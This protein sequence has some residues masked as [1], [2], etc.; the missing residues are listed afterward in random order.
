M[1]ITYHSGRRIQ[2]TENA[3]QS[4]SSSG[5]G[6]NATN[7]NSGFSAVTGLIGQGYSQSSGIYRIGTAP[8]LGTEWSFNFWTNPQAASGNDYYLQMTADTSPRNSVFYM[9]NHNTDGL[10][11]GVHD[12]TGTKVSISTDDSEMYVDMTEGS[13]NMITMTWNNTDKKLRSYK[14]GVLYET[15]K[16]FTYTNAGNMG[17]S[18]KV[19]AIGNYDNQTGSTYASRANALD[20][21]SFWS[22]TLSQADITELYNGGSGIKATA[23][24]SANKLKLNVYYDFEDTVNG[25]LTNQAPATVI[26]ADVKPTNVQLTSR[27]EET[28]TRKIYYRDDVDWKE[29]DGA[30]ATNYRSESWYEQLSGETP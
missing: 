12:S 3:S 21:W 7:G 11:I 27:Y 8:V 29:L 4:T 15:G 30:N 9:Y 16:A 19:W 28:D 18:N 17:T 6:A 20:E 26:I 14:N 23:L 5:S 2:S 22:G 10:N 25:T 1:A 24:S 13:W